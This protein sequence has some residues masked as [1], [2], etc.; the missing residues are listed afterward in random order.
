M[1]ITAASLKGDAL[2]FACAEAFRYPW[3]SFRRHDNTIGVRVHLDADQSGQMIES[4]S[5]ATNVAQAER[6]L[7]RAISNPTQ[8][9]NGLREYVSRV[10]GAQ[11]EIAEEF[12]LPE[13]QPGNQL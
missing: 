9:L 1:L 4:W 8:R 11:C 6:L 5:P 2:N 7:G 12:L 3:E 13:Q 10:L